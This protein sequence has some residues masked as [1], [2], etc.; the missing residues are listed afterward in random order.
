MLAIEATKL[1]KAYAFAKQTS[2][3]DHECAR[4]TAIGMLY[5]ERSGN[6]LCIS[7]SIACNSCRRQ[8]KQSYQA[9]LP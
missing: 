5:Q 2:C 1:F 6:M 9:A 3:F 7:Y 8:Q 4:V